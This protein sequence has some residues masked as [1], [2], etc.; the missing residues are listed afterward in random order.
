MFTPFA[1]TDCD[2]AISELISRLIYEIET[3]VERCRC[4]GRT[5]PHWLQALG[6]AAHPE[7]PLC[8]DYVTNLIWCATGRKLQFC[9]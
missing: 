7:V 6:V 5:G 9:S 1:G 2:H 4:K 8:A 3:Q